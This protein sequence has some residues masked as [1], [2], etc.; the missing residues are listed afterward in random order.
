MMDAKALKKLIDR[1]QKK[2]DAAYRNY[3]ES[4]V[5]RYDREYRNNEDL[6]DALRTALNANDE[7]TQL[8]SIRSDLAQIAEAAEQAVHH[9]DISEAISV[10]N[11]L[12]AVA[13]TYGV[14]ERRY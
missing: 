9:H 7:H 2:A 12:V 8:I 11:N 1:Y 4:G 3:Q 14:Y 5:T 6:A 13:S 10:L